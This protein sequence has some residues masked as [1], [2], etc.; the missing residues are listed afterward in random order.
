MDYYSIEII[1]MAGRMQLRR[2]GSP[3]ELANEKRSN[4]PRAGKKF[5]YG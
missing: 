5:G 3:T 2:R 1:G 4:G